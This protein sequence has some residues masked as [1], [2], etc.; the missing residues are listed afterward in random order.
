VPKSLIGQYQQS[1]VLVYLT[2]SFPFSKYR[3][4]SVDALTGLTL[5]SENN[6]NTHRYAIMRPEFGNSDFPFLW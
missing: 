5:S 4:V 3:F 1:M 2:D 6:L